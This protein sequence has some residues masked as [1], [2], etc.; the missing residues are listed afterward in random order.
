MISTEQD[1]C[2]K[3]HHEDDT[4]P[5]DVLF[6]DS[7]L[8]WWV[9]MIQYLKKQSASLSPVLLSSPQGMM[10]TSI[11]TIELFGFLAVSVY[12]L[13]IVVLRKLGSLFVI[14]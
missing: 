1:F 10:V 6:I 2:T 8:F 14:C 11:V 5:P 12:I 9:F 7:L 13:V 4:E 3:L